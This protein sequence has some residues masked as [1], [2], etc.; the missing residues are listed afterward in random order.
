MEAEECII[1]A[2]TYPQPSA[3]YRETTCVAALTTKGEFRRIFPVPF[4]FLEGDRK[5]SKWD[6]IKGKTQTPASDH[7]PESRRIDSDSIERLGRIDTKDGW[8]QRLSLIGHLIQRSPAALE[9]QRLETQRTL[10]IIRVEK[11]VSLIIEP[12]KDPDWTP[13][14]I[15]K[16]AKDDLFDTEAARSRPPLRKLGHDFWYEYMCP[17]GE[18]NFEKF[19]HKLTDWEVGALYWNCRR[20]HQ[21][22]WEKPFREKL[23]DEMQSKDL[24]LMLG[25][26]HRFPDQW[27]IIGIIYPP[28][29]T[30]PSGAARQSVFDF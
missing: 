19:K 7:R 18:G 13:E 23:F 22:Q 1:L 3:R 20:S 6:R 27:L 14:D 8:A 12:A 15:D 4:R 2:K 16:L 11:L 29:P 21:D 30:Q 25:T 26:I 10:G 5:F 9:Q 28:K 24:L 17:D